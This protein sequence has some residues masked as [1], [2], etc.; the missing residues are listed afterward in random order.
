MSSEISLTFKKYPYLNYS[1]N[2]IEN[3]TIMGFNDVQKKKIYEEILKKINKN[4]ENSLNNNEINKIITN[5]KPIIINSIS[6]DF[7]G[8][9][10]I[11]CNLLL[12]YSFSNK[13][14][15]YY[16][17]TKEKNT[18]KEESIKNSV[19]LENYNFIFF[20]NSN[21]EINNIQIKNPFNNFVYVFHEKNKFENYV[22][23]F[24]KAFLIST[25]NLNFHFIKI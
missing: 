10:M 25:Q 22:I 13:L 4:E 18:E 6:S 14:T 24:P 15:I 9:N 1:H 19:E 16:L 3:F 11:N 17:C 2:F 21:K 20:T 23:Y 8:K 12:E 5:Y 7:D